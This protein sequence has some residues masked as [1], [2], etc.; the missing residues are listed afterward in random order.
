MLTMH[1]IPT[2]HRARL[3]KHAAQQRQLTGG[4]APGLLQRLVADPRLLRGTPTPAGFD[5]HGVS[6]PRPQALKMIG[7]WWMDGALSADILVGFLF[8]APLAR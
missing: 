6:R 2:G 7:G 8:L 4:A 5:N 3:A 1:A